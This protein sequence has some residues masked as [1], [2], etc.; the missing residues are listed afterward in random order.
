MN[1]VNAGNY[2]YTGGGKN[3]PVKLAEYITAHKLV[4]VKRFISISVQY[5]Q[6]WTSSQLSLEYMEEY[7]ECV[8]NNH[9]VNRGYNYRKRLWGSSSKAEW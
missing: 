2:T 6:A 8:Y 3:D 9:D 7:K 5:K 4:L 1:V